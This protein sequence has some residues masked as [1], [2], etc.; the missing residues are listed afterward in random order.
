MIVGT[1]F[2]I[3]V[4]FGGG[5]IDTFF[6]AELEKGVKEYVVDDARK[7]ELTANIKSAKKSIKSFNK[8][9]KAQFKVYKKINVSRTTTSEQFDELFLQ[10]RTERVALQREL[11]DARLYLAKN[12][13]ADEWTSIVALSEE[14]MDKRKEKAQKKAD[15]KLAK[16]E[17]DA[18]ALQQEIPFKKARKSLDEIELDTAAH[19][20]IVAGLD[21]LVVVLQRLEEDIRAVNV[22]DNNAISRQDASAEELASIAGKMNDL[23]SLGFDSLKSFH[24]MVKENTSEAQWGKF[25]KAFGKELEMSVR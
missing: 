22:Q 19:E 10:L 24:F 20:S 11:V 25:M 5:L 13:Q 16:V 3:T 12:I 2:L 7:K 6:I 21:D 9:R 17:G 23:R 4:L 1:I 8:D 18:D 15:K 14:S